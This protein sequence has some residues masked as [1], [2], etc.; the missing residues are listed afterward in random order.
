MFIFVS[1]RQHQEIKN[2]ETK[3]QKNLFK[4][5]TLQDKAPDSLFFTRQRPKF[6]TAIG[7]QKFSD[8]AQTNLITTK[9]VTD[10]T[11][12]GPRVYPNILPPSP[13]HPLYMISIC[14]PREA[15]GNSSS[16]N[17]ATP[18][19]ALPRLLPKMWSIFWIRPLT[20]PTYPSNFRQSSHYRAG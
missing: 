9:N 20:S 11:P 5:K 18:P 3:V 14:L 1:Q 10:N 16:P 6:F 2:S 19:T 8:N 17:F 12:A 7:T 4:R 13:R 15:C